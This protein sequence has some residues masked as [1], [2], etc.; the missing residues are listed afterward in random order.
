MNKKIYHTGFT[1]A[2]TGLCAVSPT[3]ASAA[4]ETSFP[5]SV[6]PQDSNTLQHIQG[7][8]PLVSSP[9]LE[10]REENSEQLSRFEQPSLSSKAQP[11]LA[12]Q[13]AQPLA[14]SDIEIKPL[15]ASPE[16]DIE[17]DINL[18]TVPAFTPIEQ[19]ITKIQSSETE[20]SHAFDH[21][22]SLLALASEPVRELRI[23]PEPPA[24]E[25]EEVVEHDIN[26]P[27]APAF[28]PIA[29]SVPNIQPSVAELPKTFDNGASLLLPLAPDPTTEPTLQNSVIQPS[30]TADSAAPATPAPD[31]A[32]QSTLDTT[33]LTPKSSEILD[34]Y[35]LV[36]S[37]KNNKISVRLLNGKNK[38]YVLASN[39]I[40][41]NIK[42]GSLMGFNTD[43]QGRI[44]R[45][46]PPEV[47][48]VYQGTLVIVEGTKIGMVTPQGER[49]ITTLAK[50]KIVRM[51]LT[52]GQPIKITQYRG[53]WA[54]KVC[55]PGVLS[56]RQISPDA[57]QRQK[58]F[59][60]GETSPVS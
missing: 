49:F 22:V 39:A 4:D 29:Q 34:N 15:E 60:K 27:T 5:A 30:S 21:R 54:T 31:P 16:E 7:R 14:K 38:T 41:R 48:K 2:L 19:S 57:M 37:V 12:T 53:T 59:L 35:G 11:Q 1:F 43:R 51:G 8:S 50:E 24:T 6:D 25:L 33:P 9:L 47:Q 55:R 26:R 17:R 56:D 52:P 23:E 46:S 28:A 44:T 45:L 32:L 18:S 13:V 58:K 3:V 42:R 20:I 36:S 10:K 40:G